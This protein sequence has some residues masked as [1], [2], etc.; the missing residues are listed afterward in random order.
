MSEIPT[1]TEWKTFRRRLASVVAAPGHTWRTSKFNIHSL[2]LW[3]LYYHHFYYKLTQ[4]GVYTYVLHAHTTSN[5]LNYYFVII[6]S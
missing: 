2:R 6:L 1:P 5:I 3:P 4:T